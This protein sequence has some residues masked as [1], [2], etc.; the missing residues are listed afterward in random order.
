MVP[1]A[2][3]RNIVNSCGAL[4]ILGLLNCIEAGLTDWSTFNDTH[5]PARGALPRERFS[6]LAHSGNAARSRSISRP[7]PYLASFAVR[8]VIRFPVFLWPVLANMAEY[9]MAVSI[10]GWQL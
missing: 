9:A 7:K 4:S 6:S 8:V 2:A 1:E 3:G 10:V 5:Q